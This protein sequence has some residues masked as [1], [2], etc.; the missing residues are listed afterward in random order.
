[1]CSLLKMDETT[2]LAFLKKVTTDYEEKKLSEEEKRIISEFF[3]EFS[4]LQ[5]KSDKSEKIMMKYLFLG[6]FIHSN[7]G[8]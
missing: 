2:I 5:D 8:K 3:M 1:M 6:W 4:F 7:F